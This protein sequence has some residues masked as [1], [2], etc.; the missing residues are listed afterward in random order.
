MCIITGIYKKK[1]LCR[2]DKD[3]FTPYLSAEDYKGLHCEKGTFLNSAGHFVAYFTY[4]YDNCDSDKLVLFCHGLAPGHTAYFREIEYL[5]AQGLKVLA[6]DYTGCDSSEGKSTVSMYRATR[7]VTEL[8]DRLSPKEEIVIVGHSFGAFTALNVI[9]LTPR[10]K[11]GVIMSGFL[12]IKP[13]MKF[14]TKSGLFAAIIDRYER[15]LDREMAAGDNL[16]Y[17]KSTG[18]ELLF[19]ASEDDP[20]VAF[21]TG[22]G[23]A[24]TVDNPNLRFLIA[25]GKGHLPHYTD[26]ALDYMHETIGRF[27]LLV[28]QK[29]LVTFE[30]KKAYFADKSV[31]KMTD[32]DDGVMGAIIEFIR[33]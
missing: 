24:E 33:R 10:I 32:L 7:D 8:I 2:Y 3:G 12:A 14:F 30:E 26:E 17:L 27:N 9:R 11:R 20:V 19:V 6:L 18:D 5:C 23:I 28:K 22:T 15:R 29:K 13:A 4:Y 1:M 31:Y 21:D 16:E 25:S